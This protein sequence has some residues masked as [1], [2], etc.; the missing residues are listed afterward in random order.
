MAERKRKKK[1]LKQ[2]EVETLQFVRRLDKSKPFNKP[3]D[4][5]AIAE[6]N[7]CDEESKATTE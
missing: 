3:M 6:G 5:N 4:L 7:A 1:E 2:R